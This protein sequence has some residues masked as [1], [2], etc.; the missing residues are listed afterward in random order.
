[1]SRPQE[2]KDEDFRRTILR[3]LRLLAVLT[4]LALPLV[5]WKAGWQSVLLLLVG[6]GI[7]GSGT[8]EYLRLMTGIMV[9]MDGG[10]KPRTGRLLTGF[11]LRLA[12]V[13]VVL[14]VTLKYLDGSVYALAGGLGLGLI[15]LSV[16]G[17]RAM[18]ALTK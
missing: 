12:V 9:V 5:W 7:S 10:G 2:F 11:L 17:F 16:E 13:A 4:A 8:W 18:N 15:A 14:Y 1:V 3:S 6:V